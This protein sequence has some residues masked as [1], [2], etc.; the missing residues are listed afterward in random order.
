MP[1]LQD[2]ENAIDDL[3]NHP[4]GPGNY[5]LVHW[6]AEKAYEAYVFGLCLRAIEELGVIPA[7]RG[8]VAAPEPFIFR[9]GPGQIHSTRYNY[10]F[11][12]FEINGRAFEVHTGIEVTGA[13]GMMHE[14]DVCIVRHEDAEA[15]RQQPDDPPSASLV[16]G[17]ECKFYGGALDKVLGRAFVGLMDD[18]GTNVRLSGLCSNSNHDQLRQ[19]FRPRRRPYPHF[20]LSPLRPSNEAIFVNSVKAELKKMTAL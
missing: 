19:Y 1:T 2:L 14:V 4:A 18:M 8:I 3:L 10:G 16:A 20:G 17:W 13:S 12:Y 9:G 7:L 11:A 15:C 5:H 6:V